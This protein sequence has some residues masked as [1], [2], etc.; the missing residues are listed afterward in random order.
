M[1]LEVSKRARKARAAAKFASA[2]AALG[3]MAFALPMAHSRLQ[4]QENNAEWNQ[5]AETFVDMFSI[6]ANAA[7]ENGFRLTNSDRSEKI[8]R[9]ARAY[10]SNQSLDSLARDRDVIGAYQTFA[11]AHFDQAE[12]QAKE[13]KCLADAVYFEARSETRPGQ[14]AVAEVVMNRVRHPL[15]PNTICG[16]VYQGSYRNTGCQFTFTCDGSV[17]RKPRG[18]AWRNAN[19]VA[20][21]AMLGLAKPATN[22]ATHYHTVAINPYWAPSLV[23]TGVIGSHKFYR[24]PGAAGRLPDTDA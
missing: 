22:G 18:V 7:R 14:M 2:A 11:Q 24:F 20:A 9:M 17:A 3:L 1:K 21:H 5:R 12:R 23:Q 16:V 13:R 10:T 6:D 4:T 15:Y 8:W 19:Q